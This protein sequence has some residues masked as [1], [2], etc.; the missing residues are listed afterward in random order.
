MLGKY[1]FAENITRFDIHKWLPFH[2]KGHL[3]SLLGSNLKLI[4]EISAT[5][6]DPVG[7]GVKNWRQFLQ[8]SGKYLFGYL[9]LN[10]LLYC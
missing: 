3:V 9:K 6:I 2:N 1:F 4:F 8:V 10:L 5:G 7:A